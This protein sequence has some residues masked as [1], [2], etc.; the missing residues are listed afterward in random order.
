MFDGDLTSLSTTDLLES[1]ADHRAEIN[2]LEA[3][4]LEHAQLFA[5][6][7]HPDTCPPR[8]GRHLG[9]DT[10]GGRERGIVLGGD[11]CP[12]IAEFAPAEFGA[13]LGMSTYA[14]AAYIGEALALRHRFPRIG[15]KV[16][17]GTATA[18]RARK[19]AEAC[20]DLDQDSAATVDKRLARSVDTVTPQ[21][22]ENIVKAAQAH[23]D[24]AAARAK[25][26]QK[27]R[28]RGVYV[29]RSDDHGTKSIHIR[30]AS[31]NA[32]RYKAALT[33]IAEALKIFGDTRSTQTR[34]AEAVG[35]S[36][37]PRYTQELLAQAQEHLRTN[38]HPTTTTPPVTHPAPTTAPTEANPATPKANAAPQ[39]RTHPRPHCGKHA[40]PPG[41][42]PTDPRSGT[43]SG[44]HTDPHGATHEGAHG[45]ADLMTPRGLHPNEARQRQDHSNSKDLPKNPTN[46]DQ[47]PKNWT[48]HDEQLANWSSEDEPGPY[49]EADREAPHPSEGDY[50]DPLDNP[51]ST[52]V[53]PFD[54]GLCIE[55]DDG[56]PMDPTAQ[57]ALA[58]RLAQIKQDAHTPTRTS[59]SNRT[60][61]TGGTSSAGSTS[62]HGTG[63][64]SSA[65]AHLRPG[66]TEIYV[67]LTDHTLAT[68]TGVL[69][70]EAIGPLIAD[71]LTELIGH[72]PYTVKPII[73]LNDAVSVDAYEIPDKIRERVKLIHPMEVFPY[74]TRASHQ[75]I[76]LDH[77]QPYDP[78]GPPGQTSTQ[79]LAPLGRRSHRVKTH[80]RGWSVQRIDPRTLQWTTP[81]G[82][83]F[84][85]D[86]TGT[87]RVAPSNPDTP[88]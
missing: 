49:A 45:D 39:A 65:G 7:H 41:S 88:T 1:A 70:A 56:E 34:L 87:H 81:H 67:H 19:I 15:A 85:V 14:A 18:W 12:E 27:A 57:R 4:L 77:I 20:H 35:I 76:D 50:P 8:P 33:S 60:S 16:Q 26:Q 44:T 82:F 74:G 48:D 54:P 24:P 62:S 86:P 30:T 29:G 71:Q 80:A 46:H 17:V 58:L 32:I 10:A 21:R 84:Q 22:L 75:A 25:A 64:T 78:V 53:E 31:G 43:H 59:R 38:P 13:V 6:R 5:D 28:E 55:P 73:D 61:G 66:Q 11:G 79:N 9:R 23:A 83:T 68:G 51:S 47:R 69:R 36:A 40:D 42:A 3:R 72:G 2:R 63:S 37:D 52:P